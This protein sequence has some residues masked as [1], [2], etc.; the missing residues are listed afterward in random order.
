MTSVVLALA[1]TY[2]WFAFNDRANTGGMD[3]SVRCTPNL[4]IANSTSF[5]ISTTELT[6]GLIPSDESGDEEF[7]KITATTH[8]SNST[9][10]G[11]SYLRNSYAIDSSTGMLKT[12]EDSL[13][14]D[15][16][17][18][19][20]INGRVYYVDYKV[21]IASSGEAFPSNT[22]LVTVLNNNDENLDNA[23]KATSVDFYFS[24]DNEAS[25]TYKGTL[26]LAGKSYTNSNESVTELVLNTGEIPLYT[27][28]YFVVIMRCYF[29]GNL[30]DPSTNRTYI[31]SDE[32]EGLESNEVILD[33]EI[34]TR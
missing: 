21:Y 9:V 24:A 3:I 26:N 30:I 31:T 10:T 27:N 12:G 13:I 5:D 18:A 7:P 22:S 23:F 2:A 6:K 20:E 19:P 14:L 32:V 8:D 28:N 33:V 15:P 1:I 29:D 4:I 11:L 17:T 25:F 16:V 34:M